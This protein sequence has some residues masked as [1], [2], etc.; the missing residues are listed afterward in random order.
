M[1][2]AKR[3]RGH[4]RAHATSPDD[5]RRAAEGRVPSWTMQAMTKRNHAFG[6]TVQPGSIAFDGHAVLSSRTASGLLQVKRH[7]RA[8]GIRMEPFNDEGEALRYLLAPRP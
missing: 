3:C 7:I 1:R 4:R 8:Y 2:I 5:I 6:E